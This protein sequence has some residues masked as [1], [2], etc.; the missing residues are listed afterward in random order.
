MPKTL[1]ESDFAGLFLN[2]VPMMDLRAPIE[3][4]QGSF[5]NARSLPLMS[6]E[7]RVAVGTCYKQE[8]QE[9]AI[10][11]GHKLVSGE[12]KSSRIAAWREFVV[13]HPAGVLYCFRGGLRSRTTQQWIIDECGVDYPRVEG[14]YKALRRFLID[15]T[16]RIVNQMDIIVLSGRSGTGKTRLLKQLDN[17]IDLEGFANHRGSA[18]GNTTTPQPTQI[19]FENNLA[20]RL[21]KV[22]AAGY[23]TLVL[24]DESRNVGSLHVPIVL[25]NKMSQ[26]PMVNLVVSDEDRIDITVQ[27]Y[28]CDIHEAYCERFGESEGLAKLETHLLASLTKLSKRLGGERFQRMEQS[29]KAAVKQ[30]GNNQGYSGFREVFGELLLDYYDPMYDYQMSKKEGRIAFNGSRETVLK[31]LQSGIGTALKE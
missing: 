5:A 9:A 3:F 7:E 14:G 29:M 20:V 24:E 27:E 2:D 10:V 6:D 18:F 31:Y 22:E 19:N 26:S 28:A 12:I 25:H 30:L 11:L 8:G 21:L 15:S 4:S 16:E 17:A 23:T 13:Q 1:T